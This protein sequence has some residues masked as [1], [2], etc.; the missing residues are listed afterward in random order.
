MNTDEIEHTV[1]RPTEIR[2]L[3]LLMVQPE[4]AAGV[5]DHASMDGCL[6]HRARTLV[7]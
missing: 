4:L 7:R 1:V 3:P 5:G 6:A 2:R